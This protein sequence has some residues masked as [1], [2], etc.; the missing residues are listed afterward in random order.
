MTQQDAVIRLDRLN[1]FPA[2]LTDI[3]PREIATVLP[4]PALIMIPG[5]RED[6]LFVSTVLHGNET[7][8]FFVLR[9]LARK[10]GATP[11]PRS[12]MIFVGNV[13]A[14]AADARY[15]PDQHDFNRIWADGDSPFHHLVRQVAEAA[16]EQDPF[17]SIDIHNNTGTNPYYGCVNALR[18]ADLHL[19]AAFAP[20]GVFYRNPSTT[21]SV[22]FSQFCPA[23][24]I[25]CG[26]SGDEAGIA[27]ALWL[28]D[29]VAA[30]EHF[31]DHAPP[32]EAVRLYQTVGSVVVDP[33]S[34][35]AFGD[36]G[37]DLA[38]RPDLEAMNFSD[39]EAGTYWATAREPARA[40]RVIGEHG[41]D[42]TDQFFVADGGRISLKRAAT[43]AMITSDE[44]VIRQDC[45]G[46][47]M[48]P[49]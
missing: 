42:L 12:L 14:M 6:P 8:S 9:E 47:L 39:L 27:K 30:L 19:A 1:Q 44:S 23:V 46:Y 24:T 10:Y 15:L 22:A 38:L 29:H 37:A 16:R 36:S 33:A 49:L 40:L 26:K 5:E 25:E 34:S 20:V 45:L 11:P 41:D 13:R 43:P 7:T 48:A 31:P 28:I 3:G 35:I 2:G 4:N 18:P 17:A 32:D 21:Q